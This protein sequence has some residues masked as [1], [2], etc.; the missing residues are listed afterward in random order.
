MIPPCLY[1]CNSFVVDFWNTV[2]VELFYCVIFDVRVLKCY[3]LSMDLMFVGLEFL[4]FVVYEMHHIFVLEM[5][6]QQK[7]V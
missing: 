2:R 4:F 6:C 5:S 3:V 1:I 7:K